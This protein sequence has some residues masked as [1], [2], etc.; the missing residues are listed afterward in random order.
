MS[1]ATP[2]IA[3]LPEHGAANVIRGEQAI[4]ANYNQR[5]KVDYLKIRLVRSYG[6]PSAFQRIGRT[7]VAAADGRSE[8]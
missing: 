2:T 4:A 1:A 7:S 8:E 5:L 6:H 3:K